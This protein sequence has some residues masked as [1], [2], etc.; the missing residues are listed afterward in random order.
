M[1]IEPVGDS[2]PQIMNAGA[3]FNPLTL[4]ELLGQIS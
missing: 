4:R 2:V 3:K 1:V